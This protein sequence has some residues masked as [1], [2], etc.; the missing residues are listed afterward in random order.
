MSRLSGTLTLLRLQITGKKVMI[1]AVLLLVCSSLAVHL[2]IN[3]FNSTE[4]GASV[5]QSIESGSNIVISLPLP[6]YSPLMS[7]VPG[8]PIRISAEK[9]DRI[10]IT[11]AEGSLLTWTAPAS[12][13]EDNG[14]TLQIRSGETVYWSPPPGTFSGSVVL[15]IEEYQNNRVAGSS[16]VTIR[17]TDQNTYTATASN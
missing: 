9:S 12:A 16:R 13:V 10:L 8:L 7:S 15:I 6:Q 3:N 4:N 2:L 5:Q 14:K 17:S 11:T 1:A